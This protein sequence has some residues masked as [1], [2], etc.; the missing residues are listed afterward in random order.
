MMKKFFSGYLFFFVV[1]CFAN[2][3]IPAQNCPNDLPTN[4]PSFCYSFP[5]AATCYCRA[6]APGG[7]CANMQIITN[8]ML[9][10]G[11]ERACYIQHFV[12]FKDCVDNWHC[13]IYGG[14]DS[15]GR[16]CSSNGSK[17]I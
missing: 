17:C 3:S 12:S 6:Q 1:T 7:M 9:G 13:Y 11:I 8:Q 10:I 2:A 14:V 5:D 16:L 4:H 15:S